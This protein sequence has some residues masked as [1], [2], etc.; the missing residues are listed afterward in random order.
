MLFDMDLTDP[1]RAVTPTL[2]GPVLA[3]LAR[4]G[5]PLTVAEVADAAARGSE[6]GVRRCL[7]RLV[8]QG[9]VQATLMGR[10]TVHELNRQHVAA[11]VAEIL[12]ALRLELWSR[13]R[14]S[15]YGWRPEPLLACAFGSAT[16][17]DGGVDSDIDLLLVHP[18]FIDEMR[19]RPSPKSLTALGGELA[20]SLMSPGST[21]GAGDWE[22]QVDDLRARVREWTGNSLQV[23]DLSAYDYMD[24]LRTR[25][26]LLEDIRRDG[27][28]L[29]NNLNAA[30]KR[31]KDV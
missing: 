27:V 18:P 17:G 5:R 12:G 14:A 11:P 31:K 25:A 30:W 22:R 6:I 2:D 24:L 8:G 21:L 7:L 20:V 13:F 16:R 3:A 26:P 10:N 29:A 23:V 1:T 28:E 4:A 15:L 19:S 9:I